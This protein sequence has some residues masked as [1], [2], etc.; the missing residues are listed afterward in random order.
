MRRARASLRRYQSRRAALNG[1]VDVAGAQS[2][3]V[4][5]A[6][7]RRLLLVAFFAH[8][9]RVVRSLRASSVGSRRER[10]RSDAAPVALSLSRVI[11]DRQMCSLFDAQAEELRPPSPLSRRPHCYN[12]VFILLL[13]QTLLC[14]F[15]AGREAITGKIR[16]AGKHMPLMQS[17]ALILF[18]GI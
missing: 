9:S 5:A 16:V 7:S 2:G 15:L 14:G 4:G 12:E 8:A 10:L 3:S 11:C 18:R 17:R 6:R 13:Q 1:A